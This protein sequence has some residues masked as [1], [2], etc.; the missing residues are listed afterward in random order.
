MPN[1]QLG[2]PPLTHLLYLHGFRSSPQSRK[3]RTMARHMATQHP[4]VHWWCPQLPPSPREAMTLLIQGIAD[5]PRESMVVV[6]SSLGGGL[7]KLGRSERPLQLGTER[8]TAR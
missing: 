7:C 6:G 2:P 1:T 4:Q 5:W 3:A 8:H